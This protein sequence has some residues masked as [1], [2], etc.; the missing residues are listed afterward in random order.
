V[1]D[2]RPDSPRV[3]RG[4][5][6]LAVLL[7]LVLACLIGTTVAMRTSADVDGARFRLHE[8]QARSAAWSGVLAAMGELE[9]QRNELLAG[10]K[11]RLTRSFTLSRADDALTVVTGLVETADGAPSVAQS[12][13]VSLN[14]VP[15][16]MLSG[17]GEFDEATAAAIA[18][19]AKEHPFSSVEEA[20]VFATKG[21]SQSSKDRPPDEPGSGAS[22]SVDATTAS[23]KPLGVEV[24]LTAYSFD[25]EV[26]SGVG[27]TARAGEAR[28]A[29]TRLVESKETGD[30]LA[31]LI[32]ADAGPALAPLVASGAKIATRAELVGAMR[33]VNLD[34]RQWGIVLDRVR[35]GD[36][37]FVTGRVD[38]SS[39]SARVLACVPGIGAAHGEA[40][41]RGRERLAKE[42]MRSLAWPV[43]ES[44]L[45][46]DEFEKA[47]DRLTTRSAQFRVRVEGTVGART[48]DE[49]LGP[50]RALARV[51]YDAVIDIASEPARVAY[52][53]DSSLLD[54][55]SVVRARGAERR[56]PG[57]SAG[58]GLNPV[59][60]IS[61]TPLDPADP[62]AQNTGVVRDAPE[63]TVTGEASSNESRPARTHGRF[64]RW[65]P[66]PRSRDDGG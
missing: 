3:C 5:V 56:E 36:D 23:A 59:P 66:G 43:T 6:L 21:S 26:S 52:L 50:S 10:A 63:A 55:A 65:S 1:T 61:D 62:R 47:V 9:S 41:V 12:C 28:I 7:V 25:P 27:D 53:R 40:L 58:G 39:A 19:R 57:T 29:W 64:G 14:G 4:S 31:R 34:A 30:G 46:P 35:V 32:G 49:V 38:L 51:V 60:T 54:V 16:E 33:R 45:T 22:R 37:E 17:T 44:I 48:R 20:V 13:C 24:G 42:A 11:P 18:A 8:V 2:V 15:A